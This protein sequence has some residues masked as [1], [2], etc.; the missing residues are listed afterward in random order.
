[1]LEARSAEY[2]QPDTYAWRWNVFP[3]GDTLNF[4][5]KLMQALT[6]QVLQDFPEHSPEH[7]ALLAVPARHLPH[8]LDTM[9]PRLR[10]S[11]A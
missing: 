5:C 7:E 9:T 3:P 6:L 4:L 11:A 8:A 10:D 1:M 2:P